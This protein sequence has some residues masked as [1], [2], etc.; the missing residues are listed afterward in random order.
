MAN[1]ENPL[2][3]KNILLSIKSF[4]NVNRWPMRNYANSNAKSDDKNDE[5]NSKSDVKSVAN[6][7]FA[8][9]SSITDEA[10]CSSF[11]RQIFCDAS[12]L[13]SALDSLTFVCDEDEIRDAML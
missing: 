11:G 7:Q 6:K 1:C 13:L 9:P 10:Y 4:L 2:V 8:N 12:A 3:E 5:K